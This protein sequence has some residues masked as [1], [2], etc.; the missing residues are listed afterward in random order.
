MSAQESPQESP[1][2]SDVVERAR[3]RRGAQGQAAATVSVTPDTSIEP[4]A[5]RV[6]TW[7][8]VI[9]ILPSRAAC[10]APP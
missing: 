1:R 3:Q 2:E 9:S 5:P 4:T 7:R 8:P 6:S 10:Q